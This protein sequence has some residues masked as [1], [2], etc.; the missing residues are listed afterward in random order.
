V[1]H[2]RQWSA[3]PRFGSGVRRGIQRLASSGH[4]GC[5]ARA[6]YVLG[7]GRCEPLDDRRCSSS[8]LG[9]AARS[10]GVRSSLA[11]RI[12]GKG[13]KICCVTTR[14]RNFGILNGLGRDFGSLPALLLGPGMLHFDAVILTTFRLAASCL[15]AVDLPQA[16]RVLA[17]A[18]VP[19]PRL[20]LASASFAQA[21]PR[22]RSPRSGQTAV[23][24]RNVKGAHGRCFLPRES[25]GRMLPHSP[26]A[27]SK[28]EQDACCQS[29]V[30]SRTRPRDKRSHRR[31]GNKNPKRCPS[32]DRLLE[33]KTKR[34]K[35]SFDVL[36][37]RT[38]SAAHQTIK[39]A[40][41]SE[42]GPTKAHS[43]MSRR[44]ILSYR[45]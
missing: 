6:T 32:N 21:D 39:S 18:L 33:N 5:C 26:R 35:V 31:A 8:E 40:A 1:A 42:I 27:L 17:V 29:I 45:A 22:A 41:G 28:L 4:P 19:A 7:P 20:V 36:G 24:L 14:G 43:R 44:Y 13:N 16:F 23:S 37:T 34:Q 38:Q 3:D 30:F 10:W 25:S 15:P 9:C 2:R 11:D 12:W